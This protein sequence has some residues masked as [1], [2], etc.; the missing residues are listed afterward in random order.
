MVAY[1]QQTAYLTKA[2][3]QL[4]HSTGSEICAFFSVANNIVGT[5]PTGTTVTFT[6]TS[7]DFGTASYAVQYGKVLELEGLRL[8]D[9]SYTGAGALIDVYLTYPE[10]VHV[11]VATSGADSAIQ[12][13]TF[14]GGGSTTFYTVPPG[15]KATILG[16]FITVN[17]GSVG[18]ALFVGSSAPGQRSFADFVPAGIE[19]I[20]FGPTTGAPS[21]DSPRA[22]FEY[23][24]FDT[25][26][27][28]LAGESLMF[29]PVNTLAGSYSFR[30]LVEPL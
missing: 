26:P 8:Q 14:S 10:Q 21:G 23:I 28:M 27:L 17:A 20:F 12:S 2:T 11:T 7:K 3:E 25:P 1:V 13:G 6:A 4:F 5:N 30:F 9:L 18:F 16:G 24:Q 22:G 29:Q 19:T 15:C